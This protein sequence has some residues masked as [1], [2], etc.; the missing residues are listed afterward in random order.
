MKEIFKPVQGYEDLYHVSNRGRVKSLPRYRKWGNVTYLTQTRFLKQAKDKRGYFRVALCV[1][2][3]KLKTFDVHILVIKA[4]HP[5]EEG[6]THT[7]H[8]DLD[9][10]NNKADNL[11]W[12]NRRENTSHSLS[13]RGTKCRYRYVFEADNKTN[14]FGARIKVNGKQ[15]YLGCYKTALEAYKVAINFKNENGIV[16][17]YS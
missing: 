11:E 3:E 5:K 17:K 13:L 15:V 14:P 7:N 12:V 16:N 6:R 10:T 9:R 8:K 2:G 4:F 1:S